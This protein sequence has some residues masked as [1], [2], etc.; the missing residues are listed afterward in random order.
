V[1]RGGEALPGVPLLYG[2]PGYGFS[3]NESNLD[4]PPSLFSRPIFEVSGPAG[5]GITLRV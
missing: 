4:E 5:V 2:I 1:P 3:Y